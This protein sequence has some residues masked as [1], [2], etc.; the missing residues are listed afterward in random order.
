MSYEPCCA[1]PALA[2][3]PEIPQTHSTRTATRIS[4]Q[5][6]P[7]ILPGGAASLEA[8]S[9]PT[10]QGSRD[11]A[12]RVRRPARNRARRVGRP[13]D[14]SRR[15]PC[16][17][18]LLQAS[19]QALSISFVSS[20]R[21]WHRLR[22]TFDESAEEYD[23]ARPTYPARLFDDMAALARLGSGA[24]LVEIGCGTGQATTFLAER[25]FQVT[26]VEL[27]AQLA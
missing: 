26:C 10:R 9:R 20:D 27:G 3:T 6:T 4:V 16:A 23:R 7:Q 22:T 19:E 1:R 17:G 11:P 12:R 13:P 18:F 24:R 5:S 14:D 8:S 2:A 15:A 25:G 21:E